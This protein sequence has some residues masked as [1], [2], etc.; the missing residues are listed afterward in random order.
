MENGI[1]GC[2]KPGGSSVTFWYAYR[3]IARPDQQF[4]FTG[5]QSVDSLSQCFLAGFPC[6]PVQ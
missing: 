6:W 3:L 2:V 1:A 4:I 5:N